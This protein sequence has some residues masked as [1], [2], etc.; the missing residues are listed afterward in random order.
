[1]LSASLLGGRVP[2]VLRPVQNGWLLVGETYPH[3][4]KLMTGKVAN[5]VVKGRHRRKLETFDLL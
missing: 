5:Y 3:D 2:F 4:V 1:M